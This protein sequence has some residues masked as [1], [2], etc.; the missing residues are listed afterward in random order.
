M[1]AYNYVFALSC[2]I[3]KVC[4]V[5]YCLVM[6]VA[7]DNLDFYVVLFPLGY[8][9]CCLFRLMNI[10]IILGYVGMVFYFTLFTD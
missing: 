4:F 7:L 8:A 6:L 2:F 1:L 10:K 5:E 9:L 3:N